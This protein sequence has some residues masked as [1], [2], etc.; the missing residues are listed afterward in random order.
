MIEY[1][2]DI[3]GNY[4][5]GW[6]VVTCEATREEALQRL[7]E[8]NENEPQYAHKI[9]RVKVVKPTEQE[10]DSDAIQEAERRMGAN[11]T[12]EYYREMTTPERRHDPA[13]DI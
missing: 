1:E 5:Y 3:L 4:G 10:D 11:G 12:D 6:E 9:K 2:F 7:K 13:D 8:Y